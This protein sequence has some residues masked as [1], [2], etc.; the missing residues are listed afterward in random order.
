VQQGLAASMPEPEDFIGVRTLSSKQQIFSILNAVQKARTPIMIKF[1]GID[2]YF[3]SLILRT[4]LDEGYLIIDE[5]APESGHELAL[6]G[7]SFSIRGSHHGVSLYFRPN[8]VVGSGIENDIA[9]YKVPFPDEMIYQQRRTAYR[10][11]VPLGLDIQANL[12]SPKHGRLNGI[13][14]DISTGGCRLNFKGK[15]DPELVRGDQIDDFQ[16]VLT[17]GEKLTCPAL[18]RHSQFVRDWKQTSCGFQFIDL[19]KLSIKQIDRF[20]YFLQREARRL[21]PL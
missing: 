11:P 15:L 3:T 7:R 17:D 21:Q 10:A 9:F 18:V 1:E 16:L 19:D 2:R 12:I 13:L 14:F 5:I 8:V 4:N 20:V 6:Q